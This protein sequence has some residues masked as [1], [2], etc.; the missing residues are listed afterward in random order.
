MKLLCRNRCYRVWLAGRFLRLVWV[1]LLLP[2]MEHTCF[3]LRPVA[4]G[5]SV[6]LIPYCVSS[7]KQLPRVVGSAL[8]FAQH[9][10]LLAGSLGGVSP[11]GGEAVCACGDKGEGA[12]TARAATAG[13]VRPRQGLALPAGRQSDPRGSRAGCS[14]GIAMSG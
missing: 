11:V 8:T 7:V 10:P 14:R 9:S 13:K 1:L 2:E 3:R 4:V 5:M 6:S 12:G